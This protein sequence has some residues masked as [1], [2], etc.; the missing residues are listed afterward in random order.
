MHR[1]LGQRLRIIRLLDVYGALL[2]RRQQTM[3]RLYYDRDLSLG[4]IAEKL[5]VTRQA[6]H[7][8]LHR[9]IGELR[10]LESLL[11]VVARAERDAR[12]R[13]IMAGRMR[14][15]EAAINRL[16]DRIDRKTATRLRGTMASVRRAA[17]A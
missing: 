11:Q 3:L 14:V 9:S 1:A 17:G 6:V 4:E 16:A 10:R 8:S 5:R 7:D 15:L 12:E 2:T 13:H